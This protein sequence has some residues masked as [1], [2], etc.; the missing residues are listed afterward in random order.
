MC[1]YMLNTEIVLQ[2][3]SK[4]QSEAGILTAAAACCRKLYFAIFAVITNTELKLM[5]YFLDYII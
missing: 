3:R 5:N 4:R 2:N 1:M